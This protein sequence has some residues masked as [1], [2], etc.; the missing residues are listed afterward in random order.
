MDIIKLKRY[1]GLVLACLLL[2]VYLPVENNK[3]RLTFLDNTT[4]SSIIHELSFD[5]KLIAAFHSFDAQ[6][7]GYKEQY[8]HSPQH[9][10]YQQCEKSKSFSP[11]IVHEHLLQIANSSKELENLLGSLKTDSSDEEYALFQETLSKA[12]RDYAR[13]SLG[14]VKALIY[15]VHVVWFVIVLIVLKF[16][17][18]V[19]GFVLHILHMLFASVSGLFRA[20]RRLFREIHNKV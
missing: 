10:I 7:V 3:P 5:Y 14:T 19:G 17:E 8:S 12:A 2:F 6:C 15:V 9:Y 16:R 13:S 1:I 11:Y 4:L 20:I 18:N